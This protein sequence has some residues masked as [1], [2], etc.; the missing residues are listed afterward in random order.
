MANGIGR[1]HWRIKISFFQMYYKGTMVILCTFINHALKFKYP[2]LSEGNLEGGSSTG[3]F[4]RW[5]MGALR[6]ERFALKRGSVRTASG[7]DSFTGD[8]GRYV[9]KGSGYGHLS[10]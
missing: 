10:P 6:I 3:D 5:M 7:E 9:K 8:P 4:E 2:P 1:G